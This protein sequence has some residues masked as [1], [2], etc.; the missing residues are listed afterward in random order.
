MIKSFD[1]DRNI[2]ICDDIVEFSCDYFLDIA[3]ESIEKNGAFFVA[4]SGGS[5]PKKLYNKL[6]EH[7]NSIDWTK[8]YLFF[9][10]ER[11]VS[12]TNIDSNYFMA[13]ESGFKDLPIPQKQIFR[14]HA[15]DNIEE[16]AKAYQASISKFIRIKALI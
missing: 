3:K 1:K 14:M 12:S 8:V 7:K 9:S 13:M 11:S 6:K 2:A 16:N 10:D 15:E 4:L 5:T